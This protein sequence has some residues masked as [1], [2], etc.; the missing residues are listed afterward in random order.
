MSPT[1]PARSAASS[2]SCACGSFGMVA[3]SI[4]PPSV[5]PSWLAPSSRPRARRVLEKCQH[6]RVVDPALIRPLNRSYSPDVRPAL[7]ETAQTIA[8]EIARPTRMTALRGVDMAGFCY[9]G[10]GPLDLRAIPHPAVMVVV[11]FG[12]CAFNVHDAAGRSWSGSVA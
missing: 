4:V 10:D 11:E 12:D 9:R 7:T 5:D 2:R 6:P 1:S 8:W 3:S